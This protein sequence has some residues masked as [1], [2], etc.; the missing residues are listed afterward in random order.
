MTVDERVARLF[1]LDDAEIDQEILNFEAAAEAL[2]TYRRA[3]EKLLSGNGRGRG[4]SFWRDLDLDHC[5]TTEAIIASLEYAAGRGREELSLGDLKTLLLN[6]EVRTS[7]RSGGKLLRDTKSPFATII[8]CLTFPG[9]RTLFRF[10]PKGKH[11]RPTDAVSL[12]VRKTPRR[13][14]R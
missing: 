13:P 11:A 2:R 14:E 10:E 6:Y 1:L 5:E 7:E 4:E 8:R 3:R 12:A 9:N